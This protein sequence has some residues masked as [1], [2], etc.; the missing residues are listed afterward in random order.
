MFK[1]TFFTEHFPWLVLDTDVR[2][3]IFLE[4]ELLCYFSDDCSC[5]QYIVISF[6]P[7]STEIYSLKIAV[8]KFQIQKG[9]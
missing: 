8:P 1:N 7:G 4:K 3:V 5:R 6:Y 2:L 9:I